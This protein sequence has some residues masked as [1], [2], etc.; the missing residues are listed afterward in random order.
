MVYW[1]GIF[2]LIIDVF[3]L[4]KKTKWLRKVDLFNE[5]INTK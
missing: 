4:E 1:I 3:F 5:A 2:F